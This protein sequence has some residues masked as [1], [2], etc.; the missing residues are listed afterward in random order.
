[1]TDWANVADVQSRWVGPG[2]PDDLHLV[3]QLLS[4]AAQVV[5]WEYPEIADRIVGQEPPDPLPDD[6]LPAERLAM[7]L[8]RMVI[9]HIRNPDNTR[10]LT[11]TEGP[12]SRNRTFSGSQPGELLL[13][14]DERRMLGYLPGSPTQKAFTVPQP[15]PEV[16]YLGGPDAVDLW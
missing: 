11:E 3:A 13:T 9:R 8:S 12:F 16:S 10:Q 7:V 1:M 15:V 4:D 14:D 5:E 2:F 6:P